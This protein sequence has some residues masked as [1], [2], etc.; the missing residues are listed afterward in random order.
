[1]NQGIRRES[2]NVAHRF[3]MRNAYLFRN[4]SAKHSA[5]LFG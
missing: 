1:M 5:W 3:F 2:E 4:G